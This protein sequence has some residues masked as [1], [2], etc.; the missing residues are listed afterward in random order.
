MEAHNKVAQIQN[1]Y[2]TY[3]LLMPKPVCEKG[4]PERL[5][6]IGVLGLIFAGYV[7]LAS[8]S[9]YLIIVYSVANYKPH[10]SYFWTNI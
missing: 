3:V 7:P 6:P 8:Q 10:L 1:I 9:P 5:L 2:N 4:E